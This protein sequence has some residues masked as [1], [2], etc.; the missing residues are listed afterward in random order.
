MS[1]QNNEQ[2]NVKPPTIR[3]AIDGNDYQIPAQ[4]AGNLLLRGIPEWMR[5]SKVDPPDVDPNSEKIG[6]NKNLAIG[7]RAGIK[8]LISPFLPKLYYAVYGVKMKVDRSDTLPILNGILINFMLREMIDHPMEFVTDED[9]Q[10][11]IGFRPI[12]QPDSSI[13]TVE[14]RD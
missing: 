3:I 7:L 5:N 2:N 8:A 10:T 14:S 6:F 13:R 1:E 12:K 11:I 4:L 9:K